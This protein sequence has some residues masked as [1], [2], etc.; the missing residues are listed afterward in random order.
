M[1]FL[2][3]SA[4]KGI[5]RCPA[6]LSYTSKI[7]LLSELHVSFRIGQWQTQGNIFT[8]R[9]TD[10]P[11]PLQLL[12]IPAQKKNKDTCQHF[13]ACWLELGIK[14]SFYKTSGIWDL[15]I[16]ELAGIPQPMSVLGCMDIHATIHAQLA[17]ISSTFQSPHTTLVTY[18]TDLKSRVRKHIFQ[19]ALYVSIPECKGQVSYGLRSQLIAIQRHVFEIV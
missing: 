10:N 16:F 9:E 5:G 1:L 6:S 3:I 17:K 13:A 15:Q 11:F 12:C 14:V 2:S 4:R 7:M 8:N 18:I 19:S